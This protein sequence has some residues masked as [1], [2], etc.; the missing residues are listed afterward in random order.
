VNRSQHNPILTR[1]NIPDSHPDLHDVSAVFNPGAVRFGDRTALLLRVQNRGR[2]TR[3]VTAFSDDG[4]FF[5]V[6]PVPIDLGPLT[7]VGETVFHIYD[8]RITA[9][10]DDYY[11][12]VAM[13]VESGCRL[14]LAR[15]RDFEA[16]EFLGPVSD[17]NV[18]NGVLFPEKINGRYARLD[19]PNRVDAGGVLSGD[20]ICLSVSD[21]LVQWESAG[22]V[23]SGRGHYW[24]E[25]IGSGP[26]PV[27]TRAGWLH[28][29]HGI[30]TH[31]AAASI[32]QAGAVLLALD[33]PARVVARSRYNILEPRELYEQV[34]QVPNVVF[35]SGMI[36]DRFDADGFAAPDAAVSVYYGAA[37]T[38]V[39]LAT[40]TVSKLI[41]TCHE[42]GERN[43]E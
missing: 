30:A 37:D 26:P 33:D 12:M 43:H 4:V 11:I 8:P 7:S 9:I 15:T 28:I 24:D 36:V 27:K 40:T 35:P 22:T 32:Y 20:S 1:H 34:G 21:D 42:G 2:E 38:V 39:G 16:F 25:R 13:D 5:D 18:R 6:S 29:Y 3:L 31:F 17:E 23:M 10:D 14:G 41:E 19:R